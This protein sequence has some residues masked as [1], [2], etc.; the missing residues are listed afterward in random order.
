MH[1]QSQNFRTLL[2]G[3]PLAG[4]AFLSMAWV[5]VAESIS[6]KLLASLVTAQASAILIALLGRMGVEN[7]L[8]RSAAS[9]DGLAP[10]LLRHALRGTIAASSVCFAALVMARLTLGATG[11]PWVPL[12][13]GALTAPAASVVVLCVELLKANSKPVRASVVN[14]LGVSSLMTA[15][16]LLLL[17]IADQGG[18][19]SSYGI[20]IFVPVSYVGG[21]VLGLISIGGI[22]GMPTSGGRPSVPSTL[23]FARSTAPFL[24]TTLTN[25]LYAG[26]IIAIASMFLIDEQIATLAVAVRVSA[27][28]AMALV[29]V[30]YTH[31]PRLMRSAGSTKAAYRAAVLASAAL[32][33]PASVFVAL[34]G[35]SSV[36][37]SFIPN[38]D[39]GLLLILLLG[40]SVAICFGPIG[41]AV[42]ALGAEMPLA[43]LSLISLVVLLLTVSSGALLF[44]AAGVAMAVSFSIAMQNIGAFAIYQK[45][46]SY[47]V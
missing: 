35:Y 10:M 32:G 27:L 42:V 29:V 25:Q 45:K 28:P 18:R 37:T 12:T 9:G 26:S 38:I 6:T 34:V 2:A 23:G 40:Q 15:C 39:V 41:L 5:L 24:I 7:R 19:I 16:C 44:G 30:G 14:S 22:G 1:G 11:Y 4:G 31:V 46:A 47:V 43:G 33:L 17:I 21:A 8:L 36:Q 13:V 3:A 20:L